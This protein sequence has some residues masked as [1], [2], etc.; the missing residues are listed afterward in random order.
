MGTVD[1]LDK[2]MESNKASLAVQVMTNIRFRN[3][4]T[5]EVISSIFK[6]ISLFDYEVHVGYFLAFFESCYPSLIKKFMVEQGIT[7]SQI[8]AVLN[9]LPPCSGAVLMFREK[10]V[11]GEF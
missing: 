1:T 5:Y 6:D 4:M 2:K 9:I 3:I 7:R 10:I 11:N 8:L